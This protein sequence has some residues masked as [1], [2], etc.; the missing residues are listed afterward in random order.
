VNPWHLLV[1]A[2][3]LSLERICYVWVW[4]RPDAFRRFCSKPRV[5]ALGEPVD[6][7][8][9]LFYGFKLLQITVFFGWCYI[10]GQGA[11][12]PPAREEV[13]LGLGGMLM[14]I[15]QSLSFSVFHRLG[16]I[17]VFYG[18][19]FGYSIPWCDKF[20]FSVL[21]HPQYVGAVITVWGFFVATRFP[22]ADWYVLPVLQTGYYVLGACLEQPRSGDLT[23]T[24]LS[25]RPIALLVSRVTDLNHRHNLFRGRAG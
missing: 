24:V 19:K 20:P 11:F 3:S 21:S 17:G 6:V 5:A 18:N 14:L 9:K 8:C 16:K 22:H 12:V 1:A 10:H 4:H 13:W 2:A 25:S 7:L 23:L 15:G